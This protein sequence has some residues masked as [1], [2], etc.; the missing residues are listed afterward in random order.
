MRNSQP[1]ASKL[2]EIL[3]FF[4]GWV[5]VAASGTAVFA[6]MAPNI[7]TLTIFIL[8]L[9]EEFGW[10]R[11]LISGSVSAGAVSYTHLTLPTKA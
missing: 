5:V 6:R 1:L 7:T 3:P 4:Y 9:S 10:S 8:P 2:K 11:T